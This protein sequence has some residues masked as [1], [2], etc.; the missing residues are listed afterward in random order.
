M[1]QKHTSANTS[2]NKNRLPA[3]YNKVKF[4]KG[5]SV[6]D[7]GCGKYTDHIKEKMQEVGCEWFGYDK[8]NQPEDINNETKERMKIGFDIGICS[9]VLNVID[10]DEVIE[11]IIK[12]IMDC[13]KTAVFY[14]YVKDENESN[15]RIPSENGDCYQRNEPTTDYADRMVKLGYEPKKITKKMIVL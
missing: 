4:N 14:I 2:I 10:S 8:F 15:L 5:E 12:E 7:Y 11:D 9:N 13:C 1:D 6:L 3:V